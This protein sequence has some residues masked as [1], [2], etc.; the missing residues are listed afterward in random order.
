MCLARGKLLT[1][2]DLRNP[3][4]GPLHT[5]LEAIPDGLKAE[6]C[7]GELIV[8]SSPSYEHQKVVANVDRQITTRFHNGDGGPGGWVIVT[9]FNIYLPE[10]MQET[11]E[12]E[13]LRP[14]V[15]GWRRLVMPKTPVGAGTAIVPTWVCEVLS[16]N[17][18]HDRKVK[19]PFYHRLGIQHAWLIDPINRVLEIYTR[20]PI[21]W[22]R[23]MTVFATDKGHI[24]PFEEC[25]LDI[26]TLWVG[27]D[28]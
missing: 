4:K 25:E 3:V 5:A 9:D 8:Q 14:D 20:D 22:V 17:E 21:D 24:P 18:R 15:V 1:M 23:I 6:I 11:Y 19:M 2:R 7:R 12:Q 16:T 28:S 26:T 13:H 10:S 27:I